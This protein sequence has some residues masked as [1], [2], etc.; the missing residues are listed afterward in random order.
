[1]SDIKDKVK[2][3]IDAGAEKA[4]EAAD[5]AAEKSRETA[6]GVGNAVQ[7][8]GKKIADTDTEGGLGGLTSVGSA[9]VARAAETVGE[10]AEHA[11]D[12]V[13]QGYRRAEGI[14]RNQPGSA[15]VAAFGMGVVLG[16]ALVLAARPR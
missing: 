4:K 7:D 3:S 15:V 13:Q 10:Y 6:K 5:K 9:A 16:V 12:R 14:V 11:R 2:D 8:A 1:M